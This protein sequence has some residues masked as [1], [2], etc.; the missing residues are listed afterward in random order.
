MPEL[1]TAERRSLPR[2]D[3]DGLSI[4]LRVKGRIARLQ[5]AVV[6]FNRHGVA[7]CLDQPIK[8]DKQCYLTIHLAGQVM[9]EIVGVV[10]N[11][12]V[13]P[14][15]YRLGIQFRTDSALQFDR[16]VVLAQLQALENLFRTSLAEAS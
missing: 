11:C 3:A 6:D 16:D 14:D 15:G 10:H 12:T 4:T 1:G 13:L 8:K 9:H 7:V 2:F 5:G